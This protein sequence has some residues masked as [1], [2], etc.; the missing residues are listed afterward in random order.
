M[1]SWRQELCLPGVVFS[2]FFVGTSACAPNTASSPSKT[3]TCQMSTKIG[4]QKALPVV[5]LSFIIMWG[6]FREK[7]YHFAGKT[8][9]FKLVK[10]FSQVSHCTCVCG[11][12]CSTT[13]FICLFFNSPSMGR[14]QSL[15]TQRDKLTWI[16]KHFSTVLVSALP[17][18]RQPIHQALSERKT[19]LDA[20][21]SP[22]QH[23]QEAKEIHLAQWSPW[24][25]A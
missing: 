1:L 2:L 12:L 13:A 22:Q 16:W 18:G 10:T 6:F 9:H 7:K 20:P 14:S 8:W 4:R 19:G 11:I 23:G 3:R 5:F 17:G 21:T 15:K 25:Y 24:K